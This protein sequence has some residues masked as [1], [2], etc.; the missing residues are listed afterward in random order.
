MEILRDLFRLLFWRAE[1]SSVELERRKQEQD[2][3]S[4]EQQGRK[5]FGSPIRP[6]KQFTSGASD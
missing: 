1:G 6:G 2:A 4:S 5:T 3:Q